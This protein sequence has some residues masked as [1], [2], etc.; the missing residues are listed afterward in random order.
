MAL[1]SLIF[2]LLVC[3]SFANITLNK[4]ANQ[5]LADLSH[6]SDFQGGNFDLKIKLEENPASQTQTETT[7]ESNSV[8][9]SDTVPTSTET[10]NASSTTETNTL[11]DGTES[12]SIDSSTSTSDAH[13]NSS[14][15]TDGTDNTSASET[16]NSTT[17]DANTPSDGTDNSS[18][19]LNTST[20]QT[21]NSN[22]TDTNTPS[23]S[24]D[25]SSIDSNSST[26]ESES[27][28]SNTT[29]TNTPS[30]D[31]ENTSI[32]SNTSTSDVSEAEDDSESNSSDPD[33]ITCPSF[34]CS[35][36]ESLECLELD[37]DEE[38]TLHPCPSNQSCEFSQYNLSSS[39][40]TSPPIQE[41]FQAR[42][43]GN[44]SDKCNLTADCKQGNACLNGFCKHKRTEDS[45]CT[46]IDQ[47]E[48]GTI[49]NDGRCIEYFTVKS[50]EKADYSIACESGILANGTCQNPELTNGDLPKPCKK[51]ADCLASD[52]QT[53]GT[54]VCV[55]NE[56]GSSY[57]K[58]HRSDQLALEHLKHAHEGN[59]YNTEYYTRVFNLYPL[60]LFAENCY[61]EQW[62]DLN[63]LENV[64]EYAEKESLGTILTWIGV[65]LIS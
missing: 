54:C 27:D 44:S 35:S 52:G 36:V 33:L 48:D 57:C 30:D 59:R 12:T 11:I 24:T 56:A 45:Y 15:S 41:P 31:T 4:S 49:C 8:T 26:S 19:D 1:V 58:L 21:D 16:D 17:A 53:P 64:E 29:D 13:N 10:E 23:D 37:D 3:S 60:H 51:H 32:S 61:W 18:I 25:N 43:Y 38:Y 34:T 14:T 2:G 55:M 20:S 39:T 28:N 65:I 50:A 22:T 62:K 46:L 9:T 6:L 42:E 47:C 63:L 40:C 7:G 5:D